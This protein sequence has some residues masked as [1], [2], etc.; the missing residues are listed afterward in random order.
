MIHLYNVHWIYV[1]DSHFDFR[2]FSICTFSIFEYKLN[3]NFAKTWIDNLV[4]SARI[5]KCVYV[6]YIK[7]IVGGK[8]AIFVKYFD[9]K[10][11]KRYLQEYLPNTDYNWGHLELLLQFLP[12]QWLRNCRRNLSRSHKR[13]RQF[14]R[15]RCHSREELARIKLFPNVVA[16]TK[17]V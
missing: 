10:S 3:E 4:Y 14:R 8:W 15:R 12:H 6:I 2:H 9:V 13:S 17:A 5:V 16:L 11:S 1:C 7:P